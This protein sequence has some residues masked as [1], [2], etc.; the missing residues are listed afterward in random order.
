MMLMD[1]IGKHSSIRLSE[2]IDADGA[3]FMALACEMGLE[4]MPSLT[5]Q[6]SPTT[7]RMMGKE[8]PSAAEALAHSHHGL[9]GRRLNVAGK[10]LKLALEVHREL[11]EESRPLRRRRLLQGVAQ[12][13]ALRRV[14]GGTVGEGGLGRFSQQVCFSGGPAQSL[15]DIEPVRACR[16][17]GLFHV[18]G[19]GVSPRAIHWDEVRG[20]SEFSHHRKLA[21][22][23]RIF[24]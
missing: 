5:S 12:P 20:A 24:R 16:R 22:N 23:A 14:G 9:S 11:G 13:T 15:S 4:G 18:V 10:L 17:G 19:H 3:K 7:L 1:L 8:L 21:E 2:E 6:Y